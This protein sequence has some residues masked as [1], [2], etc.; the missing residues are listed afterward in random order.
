MISA[1]RSAFFRFVRTGLLA[2]TLVFAVLTGII[3]AFFVYLEFKGFYIIRRPRFIDNSFIVLCVLVLTYIIPFGIAL[4]CSMFSGSEVTGRTIN[5]KITTGISRIQI[6]IAD[7][8]VTFTAMLIYV[9]F[10]LASV[11]LFS[12]IWAVKSNIQFDKIMIELFVRLL[13]M[14]AAYA[15]AFTLL[16]FFLSNKLLGIIIT[17]AMIPSMILIPSLIRSELDKPYRNVIVNEET[18]ENYWSINPGYVGGTRR[19]VYEA[20]Y[21]AS[22]Y[23]FSDDLSDFSAE[24]ITS[25]S[26]LILSSALGALSV[27]KREYT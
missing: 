22:P 18:G 1:L 14:C 23:Y 8:A 16:Q 13:L 20:L 10:T 9:V 17:F 3:S 27:R 2:K 5:N 15:A 12:R 26:V 24:I 7:M 21:D 6:Y 11:I 4:F 19:K 25:G